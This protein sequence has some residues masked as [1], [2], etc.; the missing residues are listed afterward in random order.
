MPSPPVIMHKIAE[1]SAFISRLEAAIG[2]LR[3]WPEEKFNELALE[4]FSLQFNSVPPYRSF[5]AAKN[6]T[7][8]NVKSWR[9]IPAI[10]TEAFKEF[11]LT[12]LT[13]SEREFVFLSSGTTQMQASRHF[14]DCES[15][16]LYEKSLLPWFKHHLLADLDLR[17]FT[18][19]ILTPDS[20]AAPNSSLVHMFDTVRGKFAERNSAFVGRI[21]IP[22]TWELDVEA[23]TT[24]L[25]AATERGRPL[26]VLGTALG[27][28]DLVDMLAKRDVRFALPA[29]SRILETGGYKSRSRTKSKAEVYAAIQF[30]LG[31]AESSIISEYG[32]TELSSQAYDLSARSNES[33]P[34][35]SLTSRQFR[36]PPWAKT[37]IISPET[38]L[39]VQQGESGLIQV[40]DLTNVRSVFAIQTSDVGRRLAEGFQLL[41]RAAQTVIRGCSL[42]SA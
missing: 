12:S 29:Q 35:A 11:E 21:G 14:H 38:G 16:K 9:A 25:R 19:L 22:G 8:G 24:Y 3:P 17:D 28:L 31:V 15:M 40:F 1:H 23:A 20:A 42:H 5:C 36:F 37:R 30:H 6:A 34:H 13:S 27:F 26:I 41:G 4:L 10:P 33:S 2:E 18:F 7:P 39:D 32:M